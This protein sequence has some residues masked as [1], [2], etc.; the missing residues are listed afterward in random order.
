MVVKSPRK[1]EVFK[2]P[3]SFHDR[4]VGTTTIRP[5]RRALEKEDAP[6]PSAGSGAF[7]IAGD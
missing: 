3:P 1:M 2:P 4:Y 7:L 5:I 6:G